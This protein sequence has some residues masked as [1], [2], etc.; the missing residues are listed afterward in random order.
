MFSDTLH[1]D[2]STHPILMAEA[3]FNSKVG[4][5]VFN[6]PCTQHN[7]RTVIKPSATGAPTC[8]ANAW[9]YAKDGRV[10]EPTCQQEPVLG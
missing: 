3:A 1:A 4:A 7:R 5:E 2:V 8:A 9:R 6:A 10:Y